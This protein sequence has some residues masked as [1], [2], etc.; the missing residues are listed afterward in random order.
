MTTILSRV[1]PHTERGSVAPVTRWSPLSLSAPAP[2]HG[3]PPPPPDAPGRPHGL[4]AR[5]QPPCFCLGSILASLRP[6]L[7]SSLPRARAPVG[8]WQTRGHTG[9]PRPDTQPR[10]QS[11]DSGQW[12]P[13]HNNHNQEDCLRGRLSQTWMLLGNKKRPDPELLE[14]DC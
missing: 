13:G 14:I 11:G 2:T 9:Q 4:L 1:P 8:G 6:T 7:A 12:R 10:P 3:P 5:A